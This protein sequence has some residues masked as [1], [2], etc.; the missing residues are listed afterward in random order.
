MTSSSSYAF[1]SHPTKVSPRIKASMVI[2]VFM[3]CS[4]CIASSLFDPEWTSSDGHHS[5]FRVCNAHAASA[6]N[7]KIDCEL[8]KGNQCQVKTQ[9]WA[10]NG[11]LSLADWKKNN[12]VC[13]RSLIDVRIKR[14]DEQRCQRKHNDLHRPG[15]K[16]TRQPLQAPGNALSS[17]GVQNYVGQRHRTLLLPSRVHRAVKRC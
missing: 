17:N 12:T 10:V 1:S 11:K 8:T 15:R 7:K 3:I 5:M 6:S 13:G 16:G 14:I 9:R 2:A 4:F